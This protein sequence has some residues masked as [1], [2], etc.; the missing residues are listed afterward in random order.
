MFCNVLRARLHEPRLAANPGQV[1]NPGLGPPFSSQ[2]L[3]QL[4]AFDWKKVDPGWRPDPGWQL[5]RVH[6]NGPLESLSNEDG[7]VN[8]NVVKQWFKL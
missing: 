7:N 1:A 5:T 8:E 2:T 6:V 4:H 3:V